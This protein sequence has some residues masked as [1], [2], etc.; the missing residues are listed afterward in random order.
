MYSLTNK[1]ENKHKYYT[2]P[3]S[4]IKIVERGKKKTNIDQQK[5]TQMT[6]D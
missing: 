6:K 2:V 4:N 3:K 1:I 5:R